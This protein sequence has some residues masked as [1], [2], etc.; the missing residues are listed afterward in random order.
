ML[1]V[2]MKGLGVEI[3]SYQIRLVVRRASNGQL[4]SAGHSNSQERCF[5]GCEDRDNI[6]SST[7][8]NSRFGY[9]GESHVPNIFKANEALIPLS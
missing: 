5:S 3:G 6:R 2:G 1:I 9:S 7:N 4:M 8:R